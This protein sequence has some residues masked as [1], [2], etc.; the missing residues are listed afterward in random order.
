MINLASPL[1]CKKHLQ[2]KSLFYE[3]NGNMIYAIALTIMNTSN[4]K[5]AVLPKTSP[6][7]A[8]LTAMMI[9]VGL[10]TLSSWWELDNDGFVELF[11]N[12][13]RKLGNTA[14]TIS[15]RLMVA[16]CLHIDGASN[17]P[18]PL[19]TLRQTRGSTP[20]TWKLSATTWLP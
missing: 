19:T 8:N 4:P 12:D 9:E 17:F 10:N 15:K 18:P 1:T 5:A 11:A 6:I 2:I 13:L 20:P 16:A 7:V 3:N 14:N